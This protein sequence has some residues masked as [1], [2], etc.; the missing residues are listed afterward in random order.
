M[1]NI[2]KIAAGIVVVV[3][4]I[5]VINLVVFFVRKKFGSEKQ[6]AAVF[7]QSEMQEETKSQPEAIQ[8]QLEKLKSIREEKGIENPT[9]EDV[10]KQLEYLGTLRKQ[11]GS[12]QKTPAL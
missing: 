7:K 10:A 8:N 2:K 5:A 1:A 9:K 12:E 3:L 6:E 4:T 11:I